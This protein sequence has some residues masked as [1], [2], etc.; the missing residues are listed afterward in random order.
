VRD[1]AI[2][3]ALYWIEE[4]HLDGL[5]LDAVHAIIDDGE[6]HL[7]SEL[8]ARVRA[9]TTDRPLHLILENEDNIASRLHRSDR[10]APARYSAQWNDDVHHVL[11][12][13]ASGEDTGYYVDYLGD[14][15]KLGRALAEGF[16]FQGEVMPY[17]GSERGEPSAALPPTAFVNFIQ[18]HDQIGNRAFGDRIMAF[19][20]P[21]AVRA[22]TAIYLL[23]PQI[24][25][26]FMGEEWASD[27]PFP[28]FC[29]F[30]G[31]LA[32]AVRKGRREEFKRF[33]AFQDEAVR[34][35]I[36]D[37][38]AE[39]TFLSAKLDWDAV[40]APEHREVLEPNAVSLRWGT[41]DGA[42]LL[43]DANLKPQAQSG[44]AA[45]GGRP[46]WQEGEAEADRLGPW[47]LRWH[48]DRPA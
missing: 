5:R 32:E 38:L 48:I 3:N 21:A 15:E 14:T 40:T 36:P 7:L 45:A 8:V 11:H 42:A 41:E 25:M 24:P 1:F 31:D 34:A 47:A 10:A 44:F 35:R 9:G 12:V 18:N 46:I 37:P 28:F 4:F 17:R 29:D 16:A 30:E 43:L 39:A 27:R 23:L 6:T 33:P 22:I 13:A 26:L 19:S 20:P 2:H